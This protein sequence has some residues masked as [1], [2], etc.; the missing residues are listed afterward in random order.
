MDSEKSGLE[1]GLKELAGPPMDRKVPR[2][3]GTDGTRARAQSVEKRK[4][5]IIMDHKK[6]PKPAAG[7]KKKEEILGKPDE[8]KSAQE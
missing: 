5:K 2:Q 6:T 8:K 4:L 3:V 7:G 1:E